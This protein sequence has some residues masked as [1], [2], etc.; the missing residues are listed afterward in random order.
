MNTCIQIPYTNCKL[1]DFARYNRFTFPQQLTLVR[2]TSITAISIAALTMIFISFVFIPSPICSL[3]V[4]FS[5]ASIEI[6]VIGYMTHW[7][8]NL[9]PISMINLIMCI[10]F[11]VD[12][13]AHICYAYLSANVDTPEERVREC[14]HTL[15]LPIMQGALSTLL[16]V[17]TLVLVPSYIFV[18]FFKIVF[19]VIF[20][21]ALH[22]LF[23]I[24]V[25]LS[26]FG[27]GSCQK[28]NVPEE[29][30]AVSYSPNQ[31]NSVSTT[32]RNNQTESPV[33]GPRVAIPSHLKFDT[34]RK[35]KHK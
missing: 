32:R 25:L 12:F 9:D 3:W 11:S 29:D 34:N 35:P 6:G 26:L 33:E 17:M 31:V 15:G 16:G 30:V 14:L 18:T 1:G 4:G 13:T 7:G 5:I 21:G 19:L 24:P 8:V 28:K 23:L 2:S 27:P 10:G 20:F 22:G